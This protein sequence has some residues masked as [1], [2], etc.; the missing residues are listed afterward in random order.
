VIG[1]IGRIA[2]I[3]LLASGT[4]WAIDYGSSLLPCIKP[5][6]IQPT[7]QAISGSEQRESCPEVHGIVSA[8]FIAIRSGLARIADWFAELS[9]ERLTAYATMILAALTCFLAVATRQQARLTR[10]IVQLSRSEFIATHRPRLRVTH[11][12]LTQ[13]PKDDRMTVKF[14]IVNVGNSDAT[15]KQS[16]GTID[17]VPPSV[18]PMPRYDGLPQVIEARVFAPGTN[19][20]GFILARPER[21]RGVIIRAYGYLSYAD[22][23]G[24]IRTT[25]FCRTWDNVSQRFKAVD[26]P[27]CEYE[28]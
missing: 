7:K 4:L 14:T 20:E 13:T 28:D 11:F 27:D 8:G 25:A 21:G 15:L 19:A 3:L 23:L 17:I 26:D 18:A 1:Q 9:S 24:N 2:L 5:S 22:G 12:E 6:A 16:A 10:A